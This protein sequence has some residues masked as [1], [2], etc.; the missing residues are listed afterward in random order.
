MEDPCR[1]CKGQFFIL[2]GL[3]PV[4]RRFIQGSGG[5][6]RKKV[7]KMTSYHFWRGSSRTGRPSM[8]NFNQVARVLAA[9]L[10]TSTHDIAVQRD[11]LGQNH[12][13]PAQYQ[14]S[15]YKKK[16]RTHAF[17]VEQLRSD[18]NITWE[19]RGPPPVK[20]PHRR[21]LQPM[22]LVCMYVQ[23]QCAA[24]YLGCFEGAVCFYLTRYQR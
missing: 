4:S 17:S 5:D 20:S 3:I 13:L 11:T 8:T 10:A 14:A 9:S 19:H 18:Q 16:T 2:I 1:V 23:N 24:K 22:N 15:T 6:L 12:E 21:R 7:G